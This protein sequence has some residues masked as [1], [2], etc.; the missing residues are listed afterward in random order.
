MVDELHIKL[1]KIESNG[2]ESSMNNSR[3][4]NSLAL[5]PISTT[6]SKFYKNLKKIRRNHGIENPT[7]NYYLAFPALNSNKK[8]TTPTI[9]ST[10]NANDS[11]KPLAA[12]KLKKSKETNLNLLSWSNLMSNKNDNP[13]LISSSQKIASDNNHHNDKVRNVR[14]PSTTT[15]SSAVASRRK[16]RY[17]R[18]YKS[19]P[20]TDLQFTTK[21]YTLY[22]NATFSP[23]KMVKNCNK[24]QQHQRNQYGKFLNKLKQ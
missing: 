20:K 12:E 21:S 14:T 18:G 16:R 23:K 24:K 1:R 7:K 22:D 15:S 9:S 6:N 10:A 13:S 5:S 8:L 11:T 3:P 2:E 19:F 4:S 17:G